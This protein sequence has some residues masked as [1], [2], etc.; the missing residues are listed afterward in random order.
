MSRTSL[1]SLIVIGLFSVLL[2]ACSSEEETTASETTAAA[3]PSEAAPPTA[4][5]DAAPAV[6]EEVEDWTAALAAAGRPDSD[7]EVDAARKPAEVISFV[8]IEPGMTVIDVIAAGGYYTEVLSAAVGPEGHVYAHNTE[9]I[10]TM[11]EGKNEQAISERLAD[12]RLPNVE[13]WDREF[14][15]LG[16]DSQVDAVMYALS[17]HDVLNFRG[18]DTA[19]AVLKDIGTALKPG[20]VLG[21]IDHA[22]ISGVDNKELHRIEQVVAEQLL[23]ESG[24]VVEAQSDL[25]ANAEDDHTIGV[26]DP[27]MRRKT[28]R[29]LIRARKPEAAGE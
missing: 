6:T 21:V 29:I 7:Q 10:L 28:D 27:A 22:G 20:G 26:F 2:S 13:R 25:L 9:F 17:L 11:R 18:K 4:A 3:P 12:N 23:A 5:A 24:F 16:L 15:Q 8:G 1:A 14:G 19:L